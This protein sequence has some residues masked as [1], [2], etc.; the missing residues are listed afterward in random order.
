MTLS[1][2][3]ISNSAI[4]SWGGF[5]Y[6]GLCALSVALEHLL[7]NMSADLYLNIEGYE[8]FAILDSSK[9]VIS[10]HQCKYY[11]SKVDF[12]DE[13]QKMLA[14]RSHWASS[15]DC[16]ADAKLYF[17]CNLAL[18][19]P[20]YIDEYVYPSDN[21]RQLDSEQIVDKIRTLIK[22]INNKYDIPGN[23]ETKFIR[24][25]DLIQGCVVDI[26]KRSKQTPGTAQQISIAKAI[27]F[28]EIVQILQSPQMQI[29][30]EDAIRTIR[31]Y[32]ALYLH[33]RMDESKE[34][35]DEENFDAVD[36]FVNALHG[37]DIS[38][39]LP[40]IQRLFPDVNLKSD[41]N[42]RDAGNE[43]CANNL[44]NVVSKVLQD[45]DSNLNWSI[46]TSVGT[47]VALGNNLKSRLHCMHIVKNISN[48][49]SELFR[50]Y[51]WM[52][53]DVSEKVDD[54]LYETHDITSV[55]DVIND[56]DQ[57]YYNRIVK[58]AKLG[59]LTIRDMNDGNY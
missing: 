7:Q 37:F 57:N 55:R 26:D 54:I 43:G 51:R 53:G 44:Y 52:V 17:H 46:N 13:F 21:S 40:I 47:P 20:N 25:N 14:K 3:V 31:F 12:T 48:L 1:K 2:R 24:L 56:I 30:E 15:H 6:Q 4:A 32:L 19:Y 11:R 28:A 10:F 35:E 18:D 27:P 5:V 33:K 16:A 23:A 50:D 38:T 29:S 42:V 34:L 22:A 8:D 9:K 49:P 41:P 36:K 58:P 59:M 39:L 45:L